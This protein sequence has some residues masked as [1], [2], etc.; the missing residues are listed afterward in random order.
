MRQAVALAERVG[1]P[2]RFTLPQLRAVAHSIEASLGDWQGNLAAIERTI[3]AEPDPHY[4]LVA[5]ISHVWL[6]GRFARPSR[7]EL[8]AQLAAMDAD[9]EI[10]G[11]E[12]CLWESVLHGAEAAARLGQL[13][14]AEAALERWDA[15]ASARP[16]PPARRAYVSALLVARRDPQASLPL[17][18]H[19]AALAQDAGHDLMRLWIE[20]D[21]AAAL[22]KF[23]HDQ[24]IA[25]SKR[26]VE[27]A[28]AM[29]AL[30]ERQLALQ[31]LRTLGVRTWRRGPVADSRELTER[32]LEIAELIAAGANN[33]EIAQALFVSRK[34]VER[35]VSNILAKLGARNRAELAALLVRKQEGAPR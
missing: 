34:T 13:D 20:L 17:F 23:D 10:A 15:A 27:D 2:R 28:E 21:L 8:A 16:G 18:S 1:P 5:R 3:G 26:V 9:A 35:H 31:Q 7:P 14:L 22:A 29:A 19:A 25:L 11:C 32:E 4:R 6:T 30:S 12:R 24:A 33:P